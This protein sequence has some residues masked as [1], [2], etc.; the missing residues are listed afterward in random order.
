MLEGALAVH[1]SHI[2]DHLVEKS[3]GFMSRPETDTFSRSMRL[4]I[5]LRELR[6]TEKKTGYFAGIR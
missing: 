6:C 4:R 1:K 3:V 5:G 2:V